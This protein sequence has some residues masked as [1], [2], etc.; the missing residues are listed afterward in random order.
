[1]FLHVQLVMGIPI[2]NVTDRFAL[3]NRIYRCLLKN[4]VDLLRSRK[5]EFDM[6]HRLNNT[7]HV[8]LIEPTFTRI[9]DT[10]YDI[11]RHEN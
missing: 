7:E 3:D 5:H 2:F 9:E 6:R 1:M 11:D 10:C 4:Q 8:E